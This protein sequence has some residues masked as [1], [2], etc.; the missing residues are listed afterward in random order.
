MQEKSEKNI[1]I[2]E[3]SINFR[4]M[5][6]IEALGISQRKFSM[7]LGL[8]PERINNIIKGRNDPGYD[9]FKKII[10]THRNINTSWL[11]LGEGEMFL[12]KIQ[13]NVVNEER[14][15]YKTKVDER[16]DRIEEFLKKKHDDF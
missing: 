12:P 14:G 16:L 10:E 9:V 4:I 6:L 8:N 13:P 11:I 15:E 7:Q 3:D 1:N 5:K 2:S